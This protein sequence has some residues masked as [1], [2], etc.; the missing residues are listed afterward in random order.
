MVYLERC[1]YSQI[2]EF[3]EA[4]IPK[5]FEKYPGYKIFLLKLIYFSMIL[6][7]E[8]KINIMH[9]FN[10]DLFP[11]LNK[12]AIKEL[13]QDYFE[14]KTLLEE[15]DIIKSRSYKEVLKNTCQIF[16]NGISLCIDNL[17]LN[18]KDKNNK[19]NYDEHYKTKEL[20]TK[21]VNT[22]FNF[23]KAIIEYYQTY[24]I[25]QFHLYEQNNKYD[26][27]NMKEN[28]NLEEKASDN[29]LFN[30]SIDEKSE[31][32]SFSKNDTIFENKNFFINNHFYN[33]NN[34]IINNNNHPNTNVFD[35]Y[36]SNSKNDSNQQIIIPS[37][38]YSKY[39]HSKHDPRKKKIKEYK[40][41]QIK[42]ENADKKILRKFKKFLKAKLK[43]KTENEV[44]N[45]IKNNEFWPD[46]ISDNLMPPFS[47]EKEKICFK[48]FNTKYLC[49]FF[50]HK[51]SQELFSIFIN[52]NYNY[53][54]N[55][56]KE[57][58]KLNED[59]EDYNLLKVYINSMPMIYGN[60]GN[61]STA[62]SSNIA[63]NDEEDIKNDNKEKNNN[64][65]ED[66]NNMI[67]ENESDKDSDNNNNI[68]DI[69]MDYISNNIKINNNHN[70]N[71]GNSNN[72][73]INNQNFTYANDNS[74]DMNIESNINSKNLNNSFEK[75]NQNV[76][77]FDQKVFN[78]I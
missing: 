61:R 47:Y 55:L 39:K 15:A 1:E 11:L 77:K 78:I 23:E 19:I 40:F 71:E 52:Q 26:I 60:D 31:V 62:F 73:F 51:F 6:K 18:Q 72:E 70:I 67:I 63:E 56:V 29:D 68:N 43:E 25:N 57:A 35:S 2:L 58:Y 21:E 69:N 32:F 38:N 66:N 76:I 37:K 20:F 9:F 24:K 53:L 59:S 22:L 4:N 8:P 17:I 64:K 36:N 42:R 27:F 54:L 14:F 30:E 49:W 65:K 34:F 50:E 16:M 48:S 45:Y 75:E 28:M 10:K 7:E 3:I 5:F 44:K 33:N 74:S 41:K 13:D 46:Y 12:Y